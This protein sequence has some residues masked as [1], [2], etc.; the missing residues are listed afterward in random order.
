MG[1]FFFALIMN[2]CILIVESWPVFVDHYR[3]EDPVSTRGVIDE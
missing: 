1:R 2:Q 3:F